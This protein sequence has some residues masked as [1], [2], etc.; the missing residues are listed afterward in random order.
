MQALDR[1]V[2]R[3]RSKFS[4]LSLLIGRRRVQT[5][6]PM[7]LT[8]TSGS[9]A[10]GITELS[11]AAAA[12]T[13]LDRLVLASCMFPVFILIFPQSVNLADIEARASPGG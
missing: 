5:E 4:F 13:N 2:V 9:L 6:K 12:A 7:S 11:P 10:R 1:V 3:I 8:F